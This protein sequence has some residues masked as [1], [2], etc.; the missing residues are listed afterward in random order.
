MNNSEKFLSTANNIFSQ[1]NTFYEKAKKQKDELV[2]IWKNG[3]TISLTIEKAAT[4]EHPVA[5]L[6]SKDFKNWRFQLSRRLCVKGFLHKQIVGTQLELYIDSFGEDQTV[7]VSYIKKDNLSKEDRER[8]LKELKVLLCEDLEINEQISSYLKTEP[9]KVKINTVL[10][11]HIIVD[12]KGLYGTMTAPD[13]F[14]SKSKEDM[15]YY[16]KLQEEDGTMKVY[17]NTI[18]STGNVTFSETRMPELYNNPRYKNHEIGQPKWINDIQYFQGLI[19][20]QTITCVI[21]NYSR[22]GLFVVFKNNGG[23]VQSLIPITALTEQD[24]YL[25]SQAHP[26]NSKNDFRVVKIDNEQKR[27]TLFPIDVE[28]P[29]FSQQVKLE[30]RTTDVVNESDIKEGQLVDIEVMSESKEDQDVVYVQCGKYRGIVNVMEDMPKCL[31]HSSGKSE[32]GYSKRLFINKLITRNNSDESSILLPAIAHIV[33]DGQ[34]KIYNFSVLDACSKCL[35]EL[36]EKELT[37]N[38]RETEIVLSWQNPTTNQRYSILR[39]HNLYTFFHL[40]PK[41]IHELN[42]EGNWETGSKLTV[43]VNGIDQDLAFDAEPTD[44]SIWWDSLN[45]N[46]GDFIFIN[47]IWLSRMGVYRIKYDGCTGTILPG[48]IL[49]EEQIEYLFKVVLIDKNKQLLVVSD[50]SLQLISEA[51][52]GEKRDRDLH[53]YMPIYKNL[54]LAEDK[55]SRKWAII[56]TDTTTFV[57]L[58]VIYDHLNIEAFVRLSEEEQLHYNYREFSFPCHYNNNDWGGFFEW[59][60]L[61]KKDMGVR[62]NIDLKAVLERKGIKKVGWNTNENRSYDFTYAAMIN[63]KILESEQHKIKNWDY[64]KLPKPDVYFTGR[65]LYSNHK[66]YPLFSFENTGISNVVAENNIDKGP[67]KPISYDCIIVLYDEKTSTYVVEFDNQRG[68]LKWHGKKELRFLTN[69]K[70]TGYFDG[71]IDEKTQMPCLRLLEL[72]SSKLKEKQIYKADFIGRRTEGAIFY[73]KECNKRLFIPNKKLFTTKKEYDNNNLGNINVMYLGK[74]NFE[75]VPPLV[76]ENKPHDNYQC[77]VTIISKNSNDYDAYIN[78]GEFDGLL[79]S[80]PAH[81]VD[82]KSSVST[83]DQSLSPGDT[84]DVIVV[85]SEKSDTII[86]N[87]QNQASYS[88]QFRK[89]KKKNGVVISEEKDRYLISFD[90]IYGFCD[91]A[92]KLF[93]GK[94]YDFKIIEFVLKIRGPLLSINYRVILKVVP[95]TTLSLKKQLLAH[96]VDSDNENVYLEA[97]VYKFYA[98][99]TDEHVIEMFMNRYGKIEIN[100]GT[101]VY[102]IPVDLSIGTNRYDA[103]AK[104]V[105]IK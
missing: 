4:D 60:G 21:W 17:V 22:S 104:I 58:T 65:I 94:S 31:M 13:L 99:L 84:I 62:F 11:D 45:L 57:F 50:G 80:L 91:K 3:K 89:G 76:V 101:E 24:I 72:P 33:D 5:D 52:I 82:Y 66:I 8:I 39:W 30:Q 27:I 92:N 75:I 69:E 73:I 47:K 23:Y 93:V 10:E 36:E 48:F 85:N 67:I 20:G 70:V 79:G 32:K 15:E 74:E 42:Y 98:K 7:F 38:Y 71:K 64:L 29:K 18:D 44:P 25:W 14:H 6:K 37:P 61:V 102:I 68:I 59:A 12:Y 83:K 90:D 86:F 103:E 87:A 54:F 35:E 1:F 9:L 28:K 34:K 63:C 105:K 41:E 49:D 97:G 78:G 51:E 96:I 55:L 16:R 40:D 95:I 100:S 81:Y 2:E 43:W 77:K 26:V 19:V 53:L 56:H 46:V 88:E